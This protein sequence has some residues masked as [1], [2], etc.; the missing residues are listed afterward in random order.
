MIMFISGDLCFAMCICVYVPGRG[1][2][3]KYIALFV[4]KG[5]NLNH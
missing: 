1:D 5:G 2:L 4:I 3:F